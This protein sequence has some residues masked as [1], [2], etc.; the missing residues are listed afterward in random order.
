[1]KSAPPGSSAEMDAEAASRKRPI[2]VRCAC[3]RS[4]CDGA[5]NMAVDEA[6]LESAAAGGLPRCDSINGPSRRSRWVFPAAI[7]RDQH[8]ASRICPLV[9][10]ASGGGAI[11]HDRELT[12]SIAWPMRDTRTQAATNLYDA[13]H[14][15]L[16]EAL[17]VM[18]SGG[19][20]PTVARRLHIWFSGA[21]D[22]HRHFSVSSDEAAAT[23][24]A[25]HTKSSAAP[26]V[27]VAARCCST[28]ASC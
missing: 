24:S 22:R 16:V 5:W 15:T 11:I 21:R 8:A 20:L 27:V 10:R 14:E 19:H 23:F 17:A 28:A 9:R 18:E 4:A 12:Y 25:A 1:M 3:Y 13:C 7:D 6:L 2:N 26:S